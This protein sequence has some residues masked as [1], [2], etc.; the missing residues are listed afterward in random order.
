MKRKFLWVTA[1]I[2]IALILILFAVFQKSRREISFGTNEV[3]R[4]PIVETV[5]ASG[6]VKA[7]SSVDVGSQVSGIIQK[8]FVDFNSPVKKGQLLARIEPSTFAAKVEQASASLEGALAQRDAAL[9]ERTRSALTIQEAELAIANAA[10]NLETSKLDIINAENSVKSAEANLD[11][12]KFQKTTDLN[13][14]KRYDELLKSN[15]VSLSDKESAEN[16]Y[17]ASNAGLIAAGADLKSQKAALESARARL[18]IARANYSSAIIARNATQASL[19]SATAKINST[20]ADVRQAQATLNSARVD[21][22]RTCIYSPVDGMVINRNID[23][24]Q[25]VA[26]SFT[27]PVLF[28]IARDMKKMQ[29]YT[30]VDEADIGKVLKGQE[31]EFTVDAYPLDTFKGIISQVRAQPVTSNNVVTYYAIV[32]T[33]NPDQ[34]LKPGMTANITIFVNKKDDIL[35]IP[36]SALRFRAE[37]VEKFPYPKNY[38]NHRGKEKQNMALLWKLVAGKPIPVK[39]TTGILDNTNTELLEGDLKEG[40]ALITDTGLP[41]KATTNI[42]QQ[43][44]MRIPF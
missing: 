40:D 39:V 21:F 24:G 29:V 19:G 2:F 12:A 44:R 11:K 23:E 38:K 5:V 17:E 13:N 27:A 41:G 9:S 34:K 14:F 22:S 18:K 43:P 1:I 4:G 28:T 20:T 37:S 42:K 7:T 3:T 15:Y 31:V 8:V 26:A 6:T 16:K 25:T 32:D 10:Q 36:N 30:S 35:R 33:P